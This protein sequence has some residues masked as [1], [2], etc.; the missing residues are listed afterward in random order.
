MTTRIHPVLGVF[1]ALVFLFLL[2]P[3]VIIVG[4]SLSDTSY[5]TFR[6]RG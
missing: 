4:A 2:A 3:L 1:A 5:L 6:R